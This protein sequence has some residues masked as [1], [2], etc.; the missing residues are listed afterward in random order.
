MGLG[1]ET[2]LTVLF[3]AVW[4]AV[5]LSG[6]AS[7][8]LCKAADGL[9]FTQSG[10]PLLFRFVI[11]IEIWAGFCALGKLPGVFFGNEVEKPLSII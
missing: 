1:S 7:S 9:P 6:L 2:F 10:Q 4:G 8:I 3:R 5:V 11:G